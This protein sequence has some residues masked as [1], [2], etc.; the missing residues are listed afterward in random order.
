MK[1]RRSKTSTFKPIFQPKPRKM[2]QH[3]SV[4]RKTKGF[5]WIR[6]KRKTAGFSLQIDASSEFSLC[7]AFRL[8]SCQ[9]KPS[10]IKYDITRFLISLF[11]NIYYGP[12]FWRYAGGFLF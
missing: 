7:Y 5:A 3:F 12:T 8:K 6:E 1:N 11:L 4:P 10:P 2:L 9:L